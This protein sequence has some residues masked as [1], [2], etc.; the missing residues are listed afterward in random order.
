MEIKSK[1][2]LRLVTTK[3]WRENIKWK[4]PT[5]EEQEFLDN[6]HEL[7]EDSI[8]DTSLRQLSDEYDKLYAYYKDFCSK[9]LDMRTNNYTKQELWDKYAKLDDKIMKLKN[10]L[11]KNVIKDMFNQFPQLKEFNL[12]AFGLNMDH[13]QEELARLS[14]PNMPIDFFGFMHDEILSKDAEAFAKLNDSPNGECLIDFGDNKEKQID[15][16]GDSGL[17][18]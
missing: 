10:D 3:C 12:S 7:Y 18:Q 16:S 15:E 8:T 1:E 4:E 11:I 9:M 17:V 5:K 14:N 6:L 2:D 13:Y